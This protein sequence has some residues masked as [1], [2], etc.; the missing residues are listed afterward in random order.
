MVKI[1]LSRRYHLVMPGEI[2][3]VDDEEGRRIVEL[4]G[5][6]YVAESVPVVPV[7]RTVTPAPLPQAPQRKR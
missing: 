5:G 7:A 1:R 3:S 2:V 6:E 4:K